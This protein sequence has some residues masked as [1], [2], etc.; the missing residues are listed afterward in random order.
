MIKIIS[1]IL[2]FIVFLLASQGILLGESWFSIPVYGWCILYVL[3]AVASIWL[4]RK[5]WLRGFQSFQGKARQFWM[6][7][8]NCLVIIFFLN[9][10][11]VDWIG[12]SD[13][14]ANQAALDT[15]I[16][17][18]SPW[19]TFLDMVIL[20]PI[21]EEILFRG[22]LIGELSKKIPLIYGT[23]LSIIVF[24]GLH[25]MSWTEALIYGPVAIVISLAYV[26]TSNNLVVSTVIHM[27]NNFVAIFISMAN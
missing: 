19:L 5:E 20:A 7:V 21:M 25:V 26:F 10:V 8:I 11:L 1:T 12:I 16:H 18:I 23:L 15:V 24:T 3:S 13:E 14:T 2:L 27:V 4:Y 9:V 17:N 6:I 22:A